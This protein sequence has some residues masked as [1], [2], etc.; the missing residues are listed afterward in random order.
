[1]NQSLFLIPALG[2]LLAHGISA[3]LSLF[4]ENPDVKPFIKQAGHL[5]GQG[6]LLVLGYHFLVEPWVPIGMEKEWMIMVLL[7]CAYF[8]GHMERQTKGLYVVTTVLAWV[9][10]HALDDRL[11]TRLLTACFLASGVIFFE[12]LILGVRE[13]IAYSQIPELL[14]GLPTDFLIVAILTAVLVML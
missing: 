8:L 7:P 2:L 1:M 9:A 10:L 12:I 5:L 4:G 11:L 14:E 13:K 3:K 6:L